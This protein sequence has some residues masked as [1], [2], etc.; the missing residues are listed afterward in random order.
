[1]LLVTAVPRWSALP[2]W[3]CRLGENS[4]LSA[5]VPRGHA[6][7]VFIVTAEEDDLVVAAPTRDDVPRLCDAGYDVQYH[8]CAGAS[9]TAGAANSLPV[10]WAWIQDRLAGRPIS[11]ACVVGPPVDCPPL[12]D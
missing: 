10:Q 11:G 2:D 7:P 9:H 8:E 1:M 12:T 6:A 4:L 5:V 3:G